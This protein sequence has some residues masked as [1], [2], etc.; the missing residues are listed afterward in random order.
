MS[1]TLSMALSCTEHTARKEELTIEIKMED[2]GVLTGDRLTG[3][4]HFGHWVGILNNHVLLQ[5]NSKTNNSTLRAFIS[6]GRL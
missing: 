5:N 2:D 4:L 6:V 1:G 3:K